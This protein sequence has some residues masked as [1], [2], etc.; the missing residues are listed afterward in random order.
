MLC[1]Q[2]NRAHARKDEAMIILNW[3]CGYNFHCFYRDDPCQE[4]A[5]VLVSSSD[6]GRENTNGL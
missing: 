4:V 1:F 5:S 6:T 2:K 3:T